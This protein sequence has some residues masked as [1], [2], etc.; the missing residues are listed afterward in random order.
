MMNKTKTTP[1]QS[2]RLERVQYANL[3]VIQRD[4]ECA[5]EARAPLLRFVQDR[6]TTIA[7]EE[8]VI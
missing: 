1:S 8:E 6:L 4:Q 3:L 2:E 5:S 7:E